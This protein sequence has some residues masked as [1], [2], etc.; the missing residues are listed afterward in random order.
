MAGELEEGSNWPD[1][2]EGGKKSGG[3]LERGN[4]D[5]NTVQSIYVSVGGK[6][7]GRGGR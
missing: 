4:V 1:N 2:E 3:G 6:I 5:T 7:K